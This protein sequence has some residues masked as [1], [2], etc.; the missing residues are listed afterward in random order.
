MCRKI[1]FVILFNMEDNM[2]ENRKKIIALCCL[3]LFCLIITIL[4]HLIQNHNE[5]INIEKS[6]LTV[7]DDYYQNYLYK[8]NYHFLAV[9]AAKK[10]KIVY[11][12]S[13]FLES[14]E[15]FNVENIKST[16]IYKSCDM[17][18][19]T[20]EITPYLPIAP[21]NYSVVINLKC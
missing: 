7:V 1:H 9:T 12:L 11:S 20:I 10:S 14:I 17:E 8:E 15:N 6:L 2:L 13:N 18:Q 4:N 16:K 3:V 21:K 19:A 5:K